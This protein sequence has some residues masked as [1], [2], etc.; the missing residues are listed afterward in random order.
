MQYESINREGLYDKAVQY[1]MAYGFTNA[2]A[3]RWIR[4]HMQELMAQGYTRQEAL[5]RVPLPRQQTPVQQRT[6]TIPTTTRATRLVPQGSQNAVRRESKYSLR[7]SLLFAGGAYVAG[8]YG[9]QIGCALKNTGSMLLSGL[10]AYY[11]M[12]QEEAKNRSI[13][14]QPVISPARLPTIPAIPIL[15][16]KVQQP[17]VA[18]TGIGDLTEALQALRSGQIPKGK[19]DTMQWRKITRDPGTTL[20]IGDQGAGKTGLAYYLL[21][22]HRF[23]NAFVLNLPKEAAASLPD[24][25]GVLADLSDAPYNACLLIDEAYLRYFSRESQA[26]R[27]RELLGILAL[28]RQRRLRLIFVSQESRYIDVNILSR[29]RVLAIKKPALFQTMTDRPEVSQ[30]VHKAKAAFEAIVGDRRSWTYVY[31]GDFEGMLENPCP[32]FFEERLSCA[33]A[34][35]PVSSSEERSPEKLSRAEKKAEAKR[36]DKQ[37]CTVREIART[38][39]VSIGTVSNYLH[40]DEGLNT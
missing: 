3:V 36:L 9:D 21:S 39:G 23:S 19:G 24:E 31:S 11:R 27:A 12:E 26:K 35:M 17:S 38:L 15:S 4:G 2:E 40:E 6:P 25:I 8:K 16:S 20:I 34:D 10:T 1:L 13:L 29:V 33:F 32:A 5:E 28:A 18:Q 7:N 22:L 14:Q 30:I 37:D